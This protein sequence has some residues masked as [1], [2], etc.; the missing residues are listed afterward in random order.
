M[1]R[2]NI[3]HSK[4]TIAVR[5]TGSVDGQPPGFW[6]LWWVRLTSTAVIAAVLLVGAVA[7]DPTHESWEAKTWSLLHAIAATSIGRR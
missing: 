7:G 6:E 3:V 4:L 2:T 5:E 1:V